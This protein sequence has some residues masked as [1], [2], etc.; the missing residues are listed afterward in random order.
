VIGGLLVVL[1]ALVLVGGTGETDHGP[2]ASASIEDTDQRA[3][4]RPTDAPSTADSSGPSANATAAAAAATAE[5]SAVTSQSAEPE[6][7]STVTV[8]A[9]V[10]SSTKGH[11]TTALATTAPPTAATPTAPPATAR[12]KGPDCSN[13][14]TIDASGRKRPRPEC[15]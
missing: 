6:G 7:S 12:P 8:A 3:A 4:A 2:P 5:A 9:A 13:P 1:G 10:P 11:R 14:F 15:F